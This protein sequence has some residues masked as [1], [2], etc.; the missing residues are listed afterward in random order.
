MKQEV[1]NRLDERADNGQGQSSRAAQRRAS[2]ASWKG[3]TKAGGDWSAKTAVACRRAQERSPTT[4]PTLPDDFTPHPKIKRMLAARRQM[5]RDRQR[6]STGA[7]PKC[8]PWD[9]PAAGRALGATHRAGC[10]ARHVQPSPRRP[11]R[12]QQRQAVCPAGASVAGAGA[13]SPSSTRCFRNWRCS[14]LSMV[15]RSADP[16]DLVIW[17][18]QFGDFVNGAQPIID[19]F[20]AAGEN[21]SGN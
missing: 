17:E 7:A 18:A 16:R 6:T 2:A 10:R 21:P 5:V 13:I 12:L 14:D 11:A 3:M 20:I 1:L 19:Q 4:R 9:R 8:S 15:L